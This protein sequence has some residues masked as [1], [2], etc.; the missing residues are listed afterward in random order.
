M[1]SVSEFLFLATV[2]A[3]FFFLLTIV[4]LPI[5]VV[6]IIAGV[7]PDGYGVNTQ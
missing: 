2:D 4:G 1:N 3:V 6:A 5:P 7:H